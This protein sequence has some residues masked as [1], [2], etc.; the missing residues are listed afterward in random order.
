MRYGIWMCLLVCLASQ[1]QGQDSTYSAFDRSMDSAYV[2]WGEMDYNAALDW[3]NVALGGATTRKDSVALFKYRAITYGFLQRFDEAISDF[4]LAEQVHRRGM[5]GIYDDT[6]GALLQDQAWLYANKGDFEQSFSLLEKTLGLARQETGQLFTLETT[7]LYSSMINVLVDIGEIEK[8]ST[9]LDSLFQYIDQ[10]PWDSTEFYATKIPTLINASVAQSIVR[11]QKGLFDASAAAIDSAVSYLDRFGHKIPL[12]VNLQTRAVIRINQITQYQNLERWKEVLAMGAVADSIFQSW[13]YAADSLYRNQLIAKVSEAKARAFSGLGDLKNAEQSYRRS[14]AYYERAGEGVYLHQ[15]NCI[16][17]FGEFLAYR[18]KQLSEAVA[19]F[20]K[21]LA[22]TASL[23][24]R[25][26]QTLYFKARMGLV[27]LAATQV[28]PTQFLQEAQIVHDSFLR[29]FSCEHYYYLKIANALTKAYQDNCL[30]DSIIGFQERLFRCQLTQEKSDFFRYPLQASLQLERGRDTAFRALSDAYMMLSIGSLNSSFFL[31]SDEARTKAIERKAEPLKW[32]Y[33]SLLRKIVADTGNLKQSAALLLNIK[34][35]VLEQSLNH[36]KIQAISDS[37]FQE[38]L[39]SYNSIRKRLDNENIILPRTERRLLEQKMRELEIVLKATSVNYLPPVRVLAWQELQSALPAHSIAIDF[40]HFPYTDT[41]GHSTPDTL[42]CA[43]ITRADGDAPVLLRLAT[44]SELRSFVEIPVEFDGTPNYKH[45]INNPAQS[46]ALYQRI[47]APIE[48]YLKGIRE[49]HVS[50]SGLVANIPIGAL[51]TDTASRRPFVVQRPYNIHYY[52]SLRDFILRSD[53]PIAPQS[54][55]FFGDFRYGMDSLLLEKSMTRGGLLSDIAF[56]K[57]EQK[58][59]EAHCAA[60]GILCEGLTG[61]AGTESQLLDFLEQK[62]FDVLHFTTHGYQAADSLHLPPL[63]RV[64]IY[65]SGRNNY[66]H[67][68]HKELNGI[69]T[70]DE[71]LQLD[72]RQ[73]Q[74][75]VLSA[76]QT[77]IGQIRDT[78]GVFGLQ[79]AL[80]MIGAKQILATLWNVSDQSTSQWMDLF[81]RQYLRNGRSPYEALKKA[82]LQMIRDKKIRRQTTKPSAYW[83]GGFLLLE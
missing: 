51:V 61:E 45:Y 28:S 14:I 13:N 12:H 4:A 82:Q 7:Q 57:E 19:Q 11:M 33:S 3:Y 41:C 63:S 9:R 83:W 27:N 48:P 37:I 60:E 30:L 22:M 39:Y 10:I 78:E 2:K 79:R 24:D 62:P 64:G 23:K 55:A 42:Y 32:I 74:L 75:V 77:A 34:G 69:L 16:T 40:F 76:C 58:Q 65:T 17:T 71:F 67:Y 52:G 81:Y 29:F 5:R 47:W 21:S 50:P 49:V 72:L 68:P 56:A 59:L 54:A 26:H 53:D 6:L 44:Q 35:I 38:N 20:K 73:T 70:G 36:K 80:K 66:I 31:D 46:H 18:K 1:A 25:E 15:A 8:A 43:F